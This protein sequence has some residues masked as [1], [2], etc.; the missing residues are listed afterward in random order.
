MIKLAI[1]W[2]LGLFQLLM[3]SSVAFCVVYVFWE[4]VCFVVLGHMMVEWGI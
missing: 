1:G 3:V 4:C 2:M